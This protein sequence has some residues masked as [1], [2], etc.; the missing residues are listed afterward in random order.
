MDNKDAILIIVLVAVLLLLIFIILFVSCWF[1]RKKRRY[2]QSQIFFNTSGNENT[3]LL[4]P[5]SQINTERTTQTDDRSILL[6]CHF[7]IRTTGD[8]T[9]NSQLPLLGA[10]PNKSW[11]ILN[12]TSKNTT[13]SHLLT[14][15]PKSDRLNQLDD[16]E[17]SIAYIKTLNNL[18]NR[19]Y[20]PYV[21][22]MNKLDILY[23]QKL[24]VT[25]KQFQRSGSLKDL[26]Q[27][28]MPTVPY[29]VNKNDLFSFV[30]LDFVVLG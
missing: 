9:F 27:N 19:L 24:V 4:T 30:Y 14:I 7:Y 22:P 28:V 3:L 23:A 16:E 20:H 5:R 10:N 26:I 6:T 1:I 11:F 18:F 15:Q 17:S 29:E 21:E 2:N 25:I 12:Q 8:Y 13:A